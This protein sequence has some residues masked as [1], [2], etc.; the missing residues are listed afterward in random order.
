MRIAFLHDAPV[1]RESGCGGKEH[2]ILELASALRSRPDVS[3]AD[4][5]SLSTSPTGV[6][7]QS[8][9][10]MQVTFVGYTHVVSLCEFLAASYDVV[11][12]HFCVFSFPRLLSPKA[13]LLYHIHDILGS[14]NMPYRHLD[15]AAA[16]PWDGLVLP[17]AFAARVTS[18]WNT[19]AL[20][21]LSPRSSLVLPR[22]ISGG[23]IQPA[24]LT[25]RKERAEMIR[26][27]VDHALPE[28]AVGRVARAFPVLLFPSR[29]G[30]GKGESLAIE[31]AQLLRSDFPEVLLLMPNDSAGWQVQRFDQPIQ[32]YSWLATE[33]LRALYSA[34]DVCLAP[35]LVPESFCR[36]VPE[37]L[38]IGL[39]VVC[40]RYGQLHEWSTLSGVVGVAPTAHAVA[41][42]VRAVLVDHPAMRAKALR[43]W[44]LLRGALCPSAVAR[45]YMRYCRELLTRTSAEAYPEDL[46]LGEGV[47]LSPYVQV[48]ASTAFISEGTGST[49][50][51]QELSEDSARVLASVAPAETVG[52]V[53]GSSALQL[54]RF[55]VLWKVTGIRTPMAGAASPSV[56]LAEEYARQATVPS[57]GARAPAEVR[58]TY[59]VAGLP[60]RR[61]RLLV[62]E[63]HSDDV[64]F[65]CL[66]LA[67]EL[68]RV[69][70]SIDVW[71]FFSR[72]STRN[73]PHG[74]QWH[75]DDE[76]YGWVRSSEDREALA[77]L[78]PFSWRDLALASASLLGSKN[79]VGAF[80]HPEAT[81]QRIRWDLSESAVGYDY[82]LAPS[83]IGGHADHLVLQDLATDL[84]GA[85]GRLAYYDELPYAAQ[86]KAQAPR[87][88][89]CGTW[90]SRA[91]DR[92]PKYLAW[93]QLVCFVYQS[94]LWNPSWDAVAEMLNGWRRGEAQ[95]LETAV[96]PNGLLRQIEGEA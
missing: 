15:K 75:M 64:A 12:V 13:K 48:E 51:S 68:W 35:S 60:R 45:K 70:Y 83:G 27:V 86:C 74:A 9:G 5:Y 96:L 54:V 84:F 14:P 28:A 8:V 38:S 7:E 25:H 37:S 32:L 52:G 41:D 43:T 80:V 66:F 53:S 24:A 16:Y 89:A 73:F 90:D 1:M 2:T 20:H 56:V 46:E 34:S 42:G 23:P 91:V 77:G 11:N 71:L 58:V 78:N 67:L 26:G 31:A 79:P 10:G 29:L 81:V 40:T 4:I 61:G 50:R 82:V 62:L 22:P 30:A 65:S 72:T 33:K 19:A 76:D 57:A 85:S 3:C 36:V 94:Q 44:D 88:T 39:P 59:P 49:V 93:K 95:C 69:G 6:F 87:G 18:M 92:Q 47:Y 21:C 55:G 17:S 63:P